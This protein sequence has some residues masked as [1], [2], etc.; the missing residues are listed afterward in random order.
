MVYI[1]ISADP[2]DD[3]LIGRNTMQENKTES[4]FTPSV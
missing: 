4:P 3:G 2:T 1:Y